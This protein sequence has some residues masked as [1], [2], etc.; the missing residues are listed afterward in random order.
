M[1]H[2]DSGEWGFGADRRNHPGAH[3][4]DAP[5]GQGPARPRGP[6]RPRLGGPC[7]TRGG[8]GRRPGGGDHAPR[9]PTTRWWRSAPG[10]ACSG[11]GDRSTT[12]SPGSCRCCAR[13]PGDAVMR[14][15]ADCPLLDP[16]VIREAA[17]VFRALP[18]LDYLSTSLARTLPRGLDVEIAGPAALKRADRRPPRTTAHTS[19]PTSTRIR[20]TRGCSACLCAVGGRPAGHARHRGRL[21]AHLAGRRGAW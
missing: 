15:T 17:L 20:G 1:T 7:R 6:H 8:R 14:F 18:G 13:H 9:R 3:G 5:A 4:L 10:S 21:A 11:T 16:V 2:G 19:P 12:C